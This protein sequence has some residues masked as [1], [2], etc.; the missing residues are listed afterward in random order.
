MPELPEV[1]TIVSDLRPHVVGRTV[2]DVVSYDPRV[3][4]QGSDDFRM[5]VLGQRIENL[6]RRAKYIVAGLASGERLV[7]HLRMTGR[8]L[9]RPEGAPEDRFTRLILVFDDGQVLRYADQRHLGRV[10]VMTA[11]EWSA[12]EARLGPEP[13]SESFTLEE[14]AAMLAKHKGAI[15][16][17]LLDQ[18]FL[19]GVGNIYA[20]EALFEA[21]LH[22][23]RAASSLTPAEVARLYA[24]I[25][26]V[27]ERA[28]ANRGTTFSDYRDA[29]GQPG[30]NQFALTVYQ[31]AG[32][33]CPQQC[34]GV[35]ERARVGGRGTYFCPKCQS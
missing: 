35:V 30:R 24:G 28:I 10:L 8:L 14:F 2:V 15:K 13:L 1:E 3:V 32:Q 18:S 27:L 6:R 33:P 9:L 34:G 29:R 21:R 25:R 31:R 5:R 12:R 20:D 23:L 17:L 7:V 4:P 16:P 11:A 22:P 19:S 26:L